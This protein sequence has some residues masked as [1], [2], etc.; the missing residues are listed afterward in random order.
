MRENEAKWA[1]KETPQYKCLF[2][3]VLVFKSLASF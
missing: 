1:I 2:R 3:I